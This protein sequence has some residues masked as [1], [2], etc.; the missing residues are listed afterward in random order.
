M[1]ALVKWVVTAAALLGAAT[2]ASAF[3]DRPVSIIVPW[4]AGGGADTVTRI[5][6]A[7]FERELGVP[8]NVVNRPGGNGVVGHSAIA[9][10]TPDGYT[11]GA[12]SPEAAFYKTLGTS[13]I[14]P[15]SFD[16]FSRLALLP[17]GVTV[18]A[19]APYRSL[20]ELL[21]A[22]KD[23]PKGTF[24][25]S[26]T[27]VGGTW[28]IAVAGML[29][30]AGQEA[31]RVRWIPSLGGAPAL[32]DLVAGG[33]SMF[34]GSPIEAKSLLEAGRVRVLTLMSDEP[35][36]T[37]PG[38]PTLKEQK[39]DWTAAVWFAL[40]TP[41]GVPADR[42]AKLYE[43]AKKAHARPEVQDTLKG[44][45]ILPIW[46]EPSATEAY[47]SDVVRKGNVVLSDLGLAR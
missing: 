38:V 47:I 4:A 23:N 40:V 7:G 10:A 41:K 37:F 15:D 12:M 27:G 22:V 13:E 21:K 34:T 14:T 46:E 24:S 36:P 2:G 39:I 29:K 25:S 11:L 6:A 45:G 8:V 16:L 9:T 28:H 44:R 18:K 43:A 35:L 3:P 30:A 32:Q 19:D 26:G 17:A 42:R 5:F 33:I 31:D 20:D 1:R